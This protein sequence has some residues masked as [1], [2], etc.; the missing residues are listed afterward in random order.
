MSAY[1]YVGS[2]LELFAS[3]IN[4]KS[5]FH[6]HL[7]QYIGSNVLEVGAGIGATTRV[8][9]HNDIERW[10]CLEPDGN[11]AA[12]LREGISRRELPRCCEAR[13]GTCRELVEEVRFD[14]V[15][16]VDVLEHIEDHARELTDAVRLLRPGGNLI[17]LSPAYQ[18]LY[19]PFDKAVGHFRRYSRRSLLRLTPPG[20]RLCKAFYLDSVGFFASLGNRLLL[21]RAMP[22]ASQI[23]V[24][25]RFMVRASR[26]VDPVVRYSI[27]RSV[28]AIWTREAPDVEGQ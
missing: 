2:E 16:Y 10:V 11:M 3:A 18:F 7:S 9:C 14:T 27:G 22:N 23:E 21:R 17:V 12:T 19:S 26:W 15:L 5:Y 8:L 13:H 6:S 20:A 28:V 1:T 25:D 4:W 24:W